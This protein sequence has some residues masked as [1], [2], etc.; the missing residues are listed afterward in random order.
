MGQRVQGVNAVILPWSPQQKRMSRP[1]R[2]AEGEQYLNE[3]EAFQQHLDQHPDDHNHRMVFADWLQDRG[4]PR[5]EG[6]RALGISRKIPQNRGNKKY[7]LW[8]ALQGIHNYNPEYLPYDWWYNI[9]PSNHNGYA[10]FDHNEFKT[11]RDAE[12]A[13]AIGFT[14]LP[15]G[16]KQELLQPKQL[17][18]KRVAV[19]YTRPNLTTTQKERAK[20]VELV[21]L[22]K[23]IEG[24]KCGTCTYAK[25]HSKESPNLYCTN[26]QVHMNVKSNW[27]C[28]LWEGKNVKRLQRKVIKFSRSVARPEKGILT[29]EQAELLRQHIKT[30]EHTPLG[31]LGDSLAESGY[32]HSGEVFSRASN[33]DTGADAYIVNAHSGHTTFRDEQYMDDN[34]FRFVPGTK[35]NVH[36]L[37]VQLPNGNRFY[38]VSGY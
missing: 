30:G 23:N 32:P 17:S 9:N 3:E 12:D 21:V 7:H 38:G 8:F 37:H 4:D 10:R 34:E 24:K 27:A 31:M 36:R 13:A 33:N 20:K 16:R 11:R 14:Y 25:K 28:K 26:N 19:K 6:Y 18:R 29:P 2:Y 1:K 35:N 15:L 5:A 22:P